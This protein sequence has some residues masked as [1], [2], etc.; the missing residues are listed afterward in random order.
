MGVVQLSIMVP[1]QLRM[2]LQI[3]C[4]HPSRQNV[5]ELSRRNRNLQRKIHAPISAVNFLF[6]EVHFEKKNRGDEIC[7]APKSACE[8][9]VSDFDFGGEFFVS[10]ISTVFFFTAHFS[11]VTNF[12]TAKIEI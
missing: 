1:V 9:F 4:V 10:V 2:S 12:V 6:S 8:F 3:V 7:H 5:F 11:S